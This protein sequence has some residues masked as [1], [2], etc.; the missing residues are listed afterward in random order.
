M[1][2]SKADANYYTNS[3]IVAF[4]CN[5]RF[6]ASHNHINHSKSLE[7]LKREEEIAAAALAEPQETW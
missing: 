3:I 7:F 5:R 1:W 6:I 2:S 4:S